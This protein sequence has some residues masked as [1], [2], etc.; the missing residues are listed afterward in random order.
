MATVLNQQNVQRPTG[1]G[2]E[3]PGPDVSLPSSGQASVEQGPLHIT[4]RPNDYQPAPEPEPSNEEISNDVRHQ[5]N[6][7]KVGDRNWST[8]QGYLQSGASRADIAKT[9]AAETGMNEQDADLDIVQTLAG[10]AREAYKNGANEGQVFDY[11]INKGYDP[12]LANNAIKTAKFSKRWELHNWMPNRTPDDAE[13]LV[14]LY[15]N[16]HS[17]YSTMLK[18]VSGALGDTRGAAEYADDISKLNASM[19]KYLNKQGF[20][21][22]QDPETGDITVTSED[23]MV[24]KVD[25]TFLQS[26]WNSKYEITGAT[27]GAIAGARMGVGVAAMAPLPPTAGGLITRAAIVGGFAYGGGYVGSAA[28]RGLDL[29]MNS[30]QLKEQLEAS[31]YFNQMTEAGLADIVMGTLGA[32]AFKA[33]A[34]GIKGTSKV[35]MRAYDHVLAGNKKG[36]LSELKKI[37]HI[38][39]DQAKEIIDGFESK[40]QGQ[41]TVN[42]MFGPRAFAQEEKDLAALA[43]TQPGAEGIV[44]QAVSDN[45]QA[46][47]ALKISID[48]R[49]KD[50]N[51]AINTISDPNTGNLIREDLTAYQKDVKNFYGEVKQQGADA[52]DGTDYRFDIAPLAIEPMMKSIQKGMNPRNQ[53]L[54]LA[55]VMRIEDATTN[56]TFSGLLDLRQALNDFKYSKTGLKAPDLEA[57]NKVIN[58]IDLQVNKAVKEYM[59][60]AKQWSENWTTAKTEYAKMKQLEENVLFRRITSAANNEASIQRLLNKWGNDTDVDK[61][62]FNAVMERLSPATRSKAETAAIKNLTKKYTYGEVGDFQA[63]NFP[64]LNEAIK[65]LNI[66]TPEGRRFA[67]GVNDMAKIFKND[68]NLSSISGNLVIP[69]PAS[70]ATTFEGKVKMSI[71][72]TVWKEMLHVIPGRQANSKA[73]VKHLS[74]VLDNPMNFKSTEDFIK[75]MPETSRTEMRSLVNDLRAQVAKAPKQQPSK[76]KMYKQTKTGKLS[77]SDGALGK[78]VYLVDKV[79]K[80]LPDSKVV[81]HEV[82][83][84][85]LATMDQISSLVGRD[86]SEKEIRNI[87]NLQQQLRDAGYLGIR[88]E[89]KAMLF[90]ENIIGQNFKQPL[91]GTV[92]HGSGLSISANEFKP[93]LAGRSFFSETKEDA[94]NYAAEHGE[95]AVVNSYNIKGN[96]I[97]IYSNE[98]KNFAKNILSNKL[99]KE[100]QSW[101][102]VVLELQVNPEFILNK[103][104]DEA[105]EIVNNFIRSKN[106]D[107]LTTG[108]KGELS[109]LPERVNKILKD[110]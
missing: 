92:Y 48:R 26:L 24:Q 29:A 38:S 20:N 77:T 79:A 46:S 30:Y 67:E 21:A 54:I 56:R 95:R 32:A 14:G 85:R 3:G 110:K 89:G 7:P 80:P 76:L 9:M 96:F 75:A 49:A 15:Q 69:T 81:S 53:E 11:M 18:G 62:T 107:G 13:E 68:P 31:F 108:N 74:N 23:G 57:I 70:I 12:D 5:P 1:T 83:L 93:G 61:E 71:L 33:G 100:Y 47:N 17:K 39:D 37:L 45:P 35:V 55:H 102:D 63:T 43:L 87:P 59:P 94:L 2:L 98:F 6:L 41:Q 42:G 84:K 78:G 90:P 91:E 19:I 65:E 25:S 97:N 66:T 73:L 88:A 16:V 44:R 4:V 52:I 10:K 86:V 101:D 50:I 60:N 105:A 34:K 82:D 22:G 28:G 36:A 8:L 109:I 99:P 40:L 104:H 72:Q 103:P 106:A 64:S 51:K 27:T 58:K